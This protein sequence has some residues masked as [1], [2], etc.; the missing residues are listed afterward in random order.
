VLG[1]LSC[2]GTGGYIRSKWLSIA[3]STLRLNKLVGDSLE[4]TL[5]ARAWLS[6]V[7]R[8]ALMNGLQASFT[9]AWLDRKDE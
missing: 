7:E 3:Y 2:N 5:T 6:S 4:N 1:G 8:L 9:E